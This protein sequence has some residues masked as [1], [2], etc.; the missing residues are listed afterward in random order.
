MPRN[1]HP[2]ETVDRILNVA[3]ALFLEKGYEATTIQDI[4]DHLGGLSK[5]A[6]YHHFRSKEEIMI[7]VGD[8]LGQENAR[9]LG[10]VRD[11]PTLTGREKLVAIFRASL[12]NPNQEAMFRVALAIQKNPRFLALQLEDTFELVAPKYIQPILEQ[13]LRDG[14]IA[15]A[16]PEGLAEVMMLLANVWLNPMI[17]I[18]TPEK[19]A[20]R[21]QL[22]N[23]LMRPQLG[24]DLLDEEMLQKYIEY[25]SGYTRTMEEK[26]GRD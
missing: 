5:G 22:Y 25:C 15:A 19:M 6:I 14:T 18:S 3:L 17:L 12:R 24:F 1:K 2:E 16:D 26:G 9:M 4:I 10:A 23:D 20:Q 8:G 21:C 11:D 13:G 7:A